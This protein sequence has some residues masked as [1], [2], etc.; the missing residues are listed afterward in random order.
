M[1]YKSEDIIH[2]TKYFSYYLRLR[3][4][5]NMAKFKSKII[6]DTC[7]LEKISEKKKKCS[8]K[9]KIYHAL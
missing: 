4:L 5:L 3:R 1:A 9:I 6:I 7:D 8:K 2:E